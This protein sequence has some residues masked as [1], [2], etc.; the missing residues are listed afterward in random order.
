MKPIAEQLGD[1][2]PENIVKISETIYYLIESKNER[3]KVNLAL[4]EAREDYAEIINRSNK[5]KVLFITGIAGNNTEGFIAKSQFFQNG[6]WRT[7]SE[8][9]IELTGLLSKHQ[10]ERLMETNNPNLK[11]F[12]ISDKEFLKAAEDING[13]L[14]EGGINKDL[15]AK[16]I[17]AIL[18]ALVEGPELNLGVTPHELITSINTRVDLILK[19]DNKSEFSRF[20]KIDLPSGTDNHIIFQTALV[21]TIQELLGLN[22][23][24]AMRSGKDVLGQFY[25]VFLKYGNGA[26]EIGIV[27]TPRHVTKLAAEVMDIKHTDFVLDPTCGTGGFLVAAFDEVK[28]KSTKDDFEAFARIGLYGIEQQDPVVSLALVNMIFRGDGKNNI[29]EGDCFAK[30]LETTTNRDGE[31]IAEYLQKDS[32]ERIPPITKVLMNPPFPKKEN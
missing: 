9:D 12:E 5:I 19:K 15:R 14:H 27:L 13:Y 20:I 28:K 2:K 21:N 31:T 30:W 7:V 24:S 3:N 23:R 16:I 17:S 32:N 1:T 6:K 8:N 22:I 29:I 25:E 11:E 4:K 10:I 18:L 26:K